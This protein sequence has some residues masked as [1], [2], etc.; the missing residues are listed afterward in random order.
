MP[1]K[2]NPQ[3]GP[4]VTGYLVEKAVLLTL[5]K[6]Y[7]TYLAE[8]E[9][10]MELPKG[11]LIHP[12]NFTNRN[13]FDSQMGEKTPKIVVISP[14][15]EGQ[16]TK[17]ASSWRATWRVGIGVAVGA[18]TED[19]TD[20][21]LKCYAGATRAILLQKVQSICDMGVPSAETTRWLGESYDD[22][23]DLPNQHILYKAGTILFSIDVN[24]S[25]ARYGGPPEPDLDPAGYGT[26]DSVIID[27]EDTGV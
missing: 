22:L 15:T 6:W 7:P 2:I 9:R 1:S 17:N 13:S 20:R 23:D 12:Q 24:T 11:F 18:K 8:V 14:G 10:Q 26:A 4:I 5:R 16:P 25:V 27:L 19:D 21:I 3:F